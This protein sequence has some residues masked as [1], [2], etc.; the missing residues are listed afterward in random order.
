MKKKILVVDN[1]PTT[2]KFMQDLLEKDGHQVLTANNGLSALDTLKTFS[3]DIC[4]IDLVME[5]I[6][7]DKLCHII[8][9]SPEHKNTFIVILSAIAAEEVKSFNNY[10]ADIF[11]AKSPFNKMAGHVLQ[12][13]EL[14]DAPEIDNLKG[15]VLGHD[16]IFARE[17]TKELLSSKRHYELTLD[18]IAEGFLELIYNKIVY[19]NPAAVS[20]IG[21]PEEKL[22]SSDFI[23]CFNEEDT[24]KIRAIF[25]SAKTSQKAIEI[26]DYVVLNNKMV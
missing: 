14:M 20:V 17:I 21:V 26:D 8:R 6:A 7:G 2:L 15:K 9:E 12:V 16:E 18:H 10:H 23:N 13:L 19:A 1:H 22:L 25:E 3:P 11:I 24:K 5:N 4:F